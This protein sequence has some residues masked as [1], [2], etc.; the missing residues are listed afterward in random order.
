MP[1]RTPGR[2]DGQ[3]AQRILDPRRHFLGLLKDGAVY[4]FCRECK[5]F[6]KFIDLTHNTT[7]SRPP[8][9]GSDR[10]A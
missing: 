2:G 3:H 9:A 4:I 5:R 1:T 6:L 7:A 10:G 8:Q